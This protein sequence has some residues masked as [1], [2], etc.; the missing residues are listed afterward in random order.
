MADLKDLVEN[1]EYI[2]EIFDFNGQWDIPSKCGLKI[3]KKSNK[4]IIIATELYLNNPGTSIA[5]YC[6][7][8]AAIVCENKPINPLEVIFIVHT[9]DNK[10]KLTFLNEFF[11]KVDLDWNGE[12]FLNPK[13][14][15]V[16]K[17]EVDKLIH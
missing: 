12:K 10:S 6:P 8:L 15:S 7:Q 4:T 14:N 3:I 16:A 1:S 17:E 2:D 9:P 5:T 11:Y 13:W